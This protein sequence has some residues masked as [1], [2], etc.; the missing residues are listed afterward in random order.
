M[1]RCFINIELGE[2]QKRKLKELTD[3]LKKTDAEIKFVELENM[4]LTPR[5]LGNVSD[6][7]LEKIKEGLEKVASESKRFELKLKG[8]GVFPS[9]EY[10]KVIWAGVEKNQE[11]LDL[12][13]RIDHY[14][15]VGKKDERDFVPHVTIGRMKTK[16]E[17]EEILK[18]LDGYKNADF[19]T[20]L[21]DE[22]NVKESK[23]SPEGPKYRILFKF[24]LKKDI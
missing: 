23:L 3:E 16:K 20:V 6:K 14:I 11:L 22:I 13:K 17:K 18:I 2:E 24:E 7:Q 4:H 9:R 19:G 12:K 8:T 5:F 21:V 10:V 15:K 1:V